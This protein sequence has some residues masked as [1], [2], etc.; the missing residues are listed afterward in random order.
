M[1]NVR[2]APGGEVI[3]VKVIRSSSNAAFD[4]QAEIA[5]QKASPLPVPADQRVFESTFSGNRI[6]RSL[7]RGSK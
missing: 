1:L 2:M 3:S 7:T 5:V 6:S 4:R